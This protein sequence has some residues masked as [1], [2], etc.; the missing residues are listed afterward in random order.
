M[1]VQFGQI[2]DG[3]GTY[4]LQFDAKQRPGKRIIEAAIVHKEF[5]GGDQLLAPLDFIEE[6]QRLA[7]Y[8]RGIYRQL[9]AH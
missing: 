4:V 7:W 6:D 2:A 3:H 1:H 5:D 8:Q 9:Q